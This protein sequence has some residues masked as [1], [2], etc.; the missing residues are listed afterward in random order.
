LS[1]K[2][3][4]GGTNKLF[5][6]F[7]PLRMQRRGARGHGHPRG[8]DPLLGRHRGRAGACR[9]LQPSARGGV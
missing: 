1:V 2:D 6:E 9:R 4:Y 8:L 5:L 7:L 3:T